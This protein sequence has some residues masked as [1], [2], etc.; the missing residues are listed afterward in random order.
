MKAALFGK[1][2]QFTGKVRLLRGTS[3]LNATL[4][5]GDKPFL[6]TVDLKINEPQNFDSQREHIR[7]QSG[8]GIPVPFQLQADF[9]FGMRS[10]LVAN[11]RTA[12]LAAFCRLGYR[13]ASHPNLDVV[14][15]QLQFP[16]QQFIPRAAIAVPRPEDAP[17]G[18]T[19]LYA[20]API[21]AIAAYFGTGIV[22]LPDD[23]PSDPD[24]Y[25]RLSEAY[26]EVAPA[27][28]RGARS[29]R[30]EFVRSHWPQGM[31]LAGDFE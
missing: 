14:R 4:E 29:L 10:L 6:I 22:F 25:V 5:A 31:E 16:K 13:W 9:K 19:M 2:D 17:D 26:K 11:L 18:I 12:Y 7:E 30:C 23:G 8:Q 15:K 1:Q 20:R 3:S 27:E 28:G 24:F 21:Q